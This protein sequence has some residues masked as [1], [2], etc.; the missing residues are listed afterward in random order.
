MGKKAWMFSGQGNQEIGRGRELLES[1]K[2]IRDVAKKAEDIT[3]RPIRKIM[4]YGPK[5]LLDQTSNTQIAVVVVSLGLLAV[6]LNKRRVERPDYVIGHSVGEGPAAVAAEAMDQESVLTWTRERGIAME[7][8]GALHPGKM[9]AILGM[10]DAVV[11]RIARTNGAY[12]ANY[13]IPDQQTVITGGMDEVD[14]ASVEAEAEGAKRVI[15][16]EVTIGAHS[17]LLAGAVERVA[18]AMDGLKISD[19]RAIIAA[20]VGKLVTLG[21]ELRTLLPEQLQLPVKFGQSIALLHK[22]GVTEFVEFGYTDV[23][24]RMVKRQLRGES[25]IVRHAQDDI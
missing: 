12:V 9:A 2:E 6:R 16:L 1:F 19:P 22:E 4:S 5:E 23:L 13:N 18:R 3:N 21:S 14:A 8:E 25:V 10:K 7:E 11:E 17:P 20:N 24:S 15:P